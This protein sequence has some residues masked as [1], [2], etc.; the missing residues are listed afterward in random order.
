[1]VDALV[2]NYNYINNRMVTD[3]LPELIPFN[4]TVK[5]TISWFQNRKTGR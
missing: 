3:L 2:D 5:D 4:T 1:M